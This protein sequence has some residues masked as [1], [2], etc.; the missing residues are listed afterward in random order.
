M[1]GNGFRKDINFPG[2]FK[3][4]PAVNINNTTQDFNNL[5][6]FSSL[7]RLSADTAA[8]CRKNPHFSKG[9][10]HSFSLS[11]H[12]M[13]RIFEDATPWQITDGLR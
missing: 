7:R 2:K 3:Q 8:T 12:A 10:Y 1:T 11:G 4:D 9:Y 5:L 6:L 13:F